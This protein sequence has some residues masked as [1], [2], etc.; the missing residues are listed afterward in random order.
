MPKLKR[1]LKEN[2]GSTV[3]YVTSQQVWFER[4]LLSKL[5]YSLT[6]FKQQTEEVSKELVESGIPSLPYH[7]GMEAGQRLEVQEKFM[8]QKN[9]TVFEWNKF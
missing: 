8:T 5:G 1:F 2:P 3:V 7:A 9:I 6:C 4:A